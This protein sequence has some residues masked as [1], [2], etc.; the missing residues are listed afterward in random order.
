MTSGLRFREKTLNPRIRKSKVLTSEHISKTIALKMIWQ[1]LKI[2]N[3]N[4]A[5]KLIYKPGTRASTTS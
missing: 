5:P 4:Q 2:K 3:D 1:R